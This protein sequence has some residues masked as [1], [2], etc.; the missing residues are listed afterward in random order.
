[1]ITLNLLYNANFNY[2]QFNK[3]TLSTL[4]QFVLISRINYSKISEEYIN[5]LYLYTERTTLIEIKLKNI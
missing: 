3:E 2:L 1:M 4:F 5:I